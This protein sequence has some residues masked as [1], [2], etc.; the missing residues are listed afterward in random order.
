MD[1]NKTLAEEF[2]L[3]QE[4]IDN[5]VAHHDD[6]KT[7]PI[8]SRYKKEHTGNMDDKVHREIADRQT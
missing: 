5:T 3:R 2:K 8:I 4:Q 6:H 7:I 1:I